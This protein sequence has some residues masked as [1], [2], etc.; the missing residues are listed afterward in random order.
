MHAMPKVIDVPAALALKQ[1]GKTGEQIARPATA[2]WV[3]PAGPFRPAIE[4]GQAAGLAIAFVFFAYLFGLYFRR[5]L[6]AKWL[7]WLPWVAALG[8]VALILLIVNLVELALVASLNHATPPWQD[9][10]VQEYENP[11]AATEAILH[12][13]IVNALA[14]CSFQAEKLS[15]IQHEVAF[16]VPIGDYT[17]GMAYGRRPTAATVGAVSSSSSL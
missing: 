5:T 14:G 10:A 12:G 4:V 11:E 2:Q 6:K 7:V 13:L 16:P 17:P 15:A 8:A 3:A 9:V 1:S